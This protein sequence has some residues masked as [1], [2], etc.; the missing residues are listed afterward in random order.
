MN[1]KIQFNN[2]IEILLNSQIEGETLD[3]AFYTDAEIFNHEMKAIWE[4]EWLFVAMS[5]ELEE[6]GAWITVDISNYSIILFRG[7]DNIIR[8]FHNTCRHRGSK[9]CLEHKGKSRNLVCPYH[10]W[11]Y[12]GKGDLIHARSMPIDFDKSQHSLKEVHINN[13][14]GYLFICLS[15]NP[16]SFEDFSN[17]VTPY[18]IPHELSN[19]KVAYKMT[20]IEEA[21]WKLVIENNRECYHCRVGH[22][23]LLNT[24]AEVEDT[25]DPNCPKE[26]LPKSEA[27]KK[28]WDSQNLPYKLHADPDGWQIVRVPMYKGLS[29][30]MDGQ[31][32]SDKVMGSLPDFDVGSVRVLHF[33]N[34][35]NHALG[36][37]AISFSVLPLG[38]TKTAV[39]TRW[40]VHK[41]AI[42]GTNYDIE[43]LTKV[44]LATN[45]QDKTLAENNQ[46]GINSPAFTKGIYSPET[47]YGVMAFIRWYLDR[48]K[49]HII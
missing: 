5:C 31:P 17:V 23:E 4:N 1:Q 8:A 20:I 24:I 34:T 25:N 47:E 10:Q 39:T 3:R 21:N 7:M 43:N 26:Y 40:L 13:I 14:E 33:P 19:A 2:S 9:I 45:D 12:N 6:P 29:F 15:D 36:D 27:D 30:T 49:K 48:M 18:L 37:H 35:W 32:A 22:P 42:E 11:T 28:R 16:P 44:W 41:D 46:L 38:P